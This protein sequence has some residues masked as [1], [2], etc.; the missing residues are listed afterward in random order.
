M[1]TCV[2]NMYT[3]MINKAKKKLMRKITPCKSVN[4]EY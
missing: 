2:K 3:C 4:Y 1:C